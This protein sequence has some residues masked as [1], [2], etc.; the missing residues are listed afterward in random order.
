MT[1]HAKLSASGSATWINCAGSVK[2]QEGLPNVT[3][4]YSAEGILAHDVAAAI[5]EGK[6]KR[7]GKFK[8]L[9]SDMVENVSIYTDYINNIFTQLEETSG[10]SPSVF[11]EAKVEY[12]QIAE[13]QFGTADCIIQGEDEL[14]VIDLKYGQGVRV[15]AEDNTQLLLYAIGSLNFLKGNSTIEYKPATISMHIV[16]P[17]INN[18]S[19]WTITFEELV[20]WT[21]FIHERALEALKPDAI[22]TPNE[23]ACMWC[24]AKPTCPA[25]YKFVNEEI[26]I[27]KEKTNLDDNELKLILDNSKLIL[28][29]LK[30]V[31]DNVYDRLSSGATL[32]GYKLV[33]GRSYRKFKSELTEDQERLLM[34]I[35]KLTPPTLA[36][37][38]KVFGVEIV[39][40]LTYKQTGKPSLVK[41]SDKRESINTFDFE[42]VGCNEKN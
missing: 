9:P 2:A 37:A 35:S 41:S 30:S 39:N 19:K 38:E 21:K 29:F 13:G 33:D 20:K 12:Q 18:Y 25:I 32:D 6:F 42:D 27:L 15:D 5:L 4:T 1:K 17:R 16:Q 31:G 34:S 10:C 7:G 23:K 22:R 14:H 28:G 36:E 8:N 40:E 3:S 11:I 26:M 24:K